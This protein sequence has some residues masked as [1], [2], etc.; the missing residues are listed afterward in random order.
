VSPSPK[1]S[2]ARI[3]VTLLMD[4]VVVIAVVGLAHLVISFF[5]TTAGTAWGKGLLGLT[6]LVVVPLGIPPVPTPYGGIFDVNATA[7]VLGLLGV[8]WVLGLVRRNA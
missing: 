6:R 4:L 5:D 2:P 7:T 1:S 3:I 8:E